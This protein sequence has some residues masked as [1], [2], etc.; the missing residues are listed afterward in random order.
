M[1]RHKYNI[2]N[3]HCASPVDPSTISTFLIV[4]NLR[5]KSVNVRGKGR[6]FV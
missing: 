6:H 4:V 5:T 2:V 1:S 3:Y